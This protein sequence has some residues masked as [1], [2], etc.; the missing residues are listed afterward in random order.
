MSVVSDISIHPMWLLWYFSHSHKC[1]PQCSAR[2]KARGTTQSR[3][4]IVW[5]P[6]PRGGQWSIKVTDQHY[7]N[8][9]ILR[10]ELLVVWQERRVSHTCTII[11]W[12][13]GSSF[14][15]ACVTRE[16]SVQATVFSAPLFCLFYSCR[17]TRTANSP[18]GRVNLFFA[19]AKQLRQPRTS[20]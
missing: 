15:S 9:A 10:V 12:T 2:K 16:T 4:S 11:V 8:A 6:W 14:F 18:T 17:N 19:K 1:K 3:A 5:E 20:A 7:T 13:K